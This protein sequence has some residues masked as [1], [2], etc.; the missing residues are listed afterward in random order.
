[1]TAPDALPP[2]VEVAPEPDRTAKNAVFFEGLG[3]GLL[4]SVNSLIAL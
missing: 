2:A 3:S 4:F 1:M